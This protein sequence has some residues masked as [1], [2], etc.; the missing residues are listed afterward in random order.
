MLRALAF[1]ALVLWLI[2]GF[3]PAGTSFTASSQP[4]A[5]LCSMATVAMWFHL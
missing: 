3:L 5:R 1:A 2:S 4:Q